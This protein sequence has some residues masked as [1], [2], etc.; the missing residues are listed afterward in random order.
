MGFIK[1]LFD[2]A[3]NGTLNYE[4]FEVACK[5]ANIKLANLSEGGYVSKQKYDDDISTRDT[6]LRNVKDQLEK[7]NGNE[8]KL[9]TLTANLENLQNKYNAQA[10]EFA[11]KDFASTKKFTSNAAKRDFVSSMIAKNLN[12]E[13][14]K[15]LGAE[16]FVTAYSADNADAFVS[17]NA[18]PPKPQPQFVGKTTPL[19]EVTNTVTKEQFNKMNY[20]QMNELFR[21]NKQLFNKLSE[22]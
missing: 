21:S 19:S 14:G 2:N 17:E 5:S 3:E 20:S 13:N 4:Q 18:E 22:E 12:I 10:Y 9:K 11:V 7:A 6:D 1:E 16:D 8:E 15:I